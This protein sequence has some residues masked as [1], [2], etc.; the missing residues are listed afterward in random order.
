MRVR[1]EGKSEVAFSVEHA[2]FYRYTNALYYIA[3]R[4][5]IITNSPRF[6]IVLIYHAPFAALFYLHEE[7]IRTLRI[8]STSFY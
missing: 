4:S 5:S 2:R 7:S 8:L 6:T 3:R 1:G